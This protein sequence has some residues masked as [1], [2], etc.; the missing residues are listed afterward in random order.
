MNLCVFCV[1]TRASLWNQGPPSEKANKGELQTQQRD[2]CAEAP[3]RLEEDHDDQPVRGAA[4]CAHSACESFFTPAI[5][6]G[7]VH[8]GHTFHANTVLCGK[9]KVYVDLSWHSI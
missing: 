7:P 8:R 3:E 9:L 1:Q 2:R 4:A 6:L 5:P